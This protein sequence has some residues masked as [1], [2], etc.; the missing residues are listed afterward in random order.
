MRP[1][2]T[3]PTRP[4]CCALPDS[5]FV[6]AVWAGCPPTPLDA[7]FPLFFIY[8]SGS[9]G[10]PKGVVHV[11]GGWLAGVAHT[12]QVAFDARPGD[13]IYVVADPGWITGQSYM[14][15]A[16]LA[17]RCTGV[18]GEGAPIF[19]HAGRFASI[20]ERY[21]VRIF[22]AG[23]TFLKTV[24]TDPQNASDVRQYDMSTPARGHLLCRADSARRCS[25]S[26]ME[27]MTPQYINSLL[28][29]RARRHRV[30][31]LLRQCRLSAA[32]RCAH[33]PAAVDRRRGLGRGCRRHGRNRAAAC[34][35]SGAG[36]V[37]WRRA[38]PGEK[39]EIVIAAPYPYLA[40]T[41]WGDAAR[42]HV[43][44]GR[45]QAGWQGDARR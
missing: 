7:E 8:T 30:D 17:L 29:H 11:H 13:V 43:E 15:S 39:G 20:I 18:L 32:R 4:R 2:S 24:M 1:A 38:E 45:V 22:K 12:M 42:F 41:I 37:A 9:T 27:L 21:G 5:D 25:S 19:P 34:T 6:R 44:D 3:S 28:G 31:A 36:G 16:T 33:L 26:A 35:R 10:K 23:V 14:L 40:R